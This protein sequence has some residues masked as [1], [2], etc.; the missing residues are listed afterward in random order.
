MHSS[1]YTDIVVDR[2]IDI[3][4]L[5]GTLAAAANLSVILVQE[6]DSIHAAVD[7]DNYKEVVLV[8]EP[9][10]LKQNHN[11]RKNVRHVLPGNGIW[12]TNMFDT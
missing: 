3:P 6:F 2:D 9:A 5:A 10:S 11:C 7:F 8:P 12:G 1:Q 4:P